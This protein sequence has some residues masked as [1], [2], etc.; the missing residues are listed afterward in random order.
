MS[1]QN[2]NHHVV[3][4]EDVKKDLQLGEVTVHAVRG[5]S[6]SVE[7][8][9]SWQ[10]RRL[11]KFVA[12]SCVGAIRVPRRPLATGGLPHP[13]ADVPTGARLGRPA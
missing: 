8:G 13:I 1:N 7:R 10:A 3:R 9:M 12:R 4:T 11:T 2:G 6:L 5:V